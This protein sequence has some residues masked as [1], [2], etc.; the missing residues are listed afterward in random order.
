MSGGEILGRL[1]AE[2]ANPKA[3]IWYGGSADS[4]VTAQSE[5]LLTP[6]ISP[7]AADISSQQKDPEGYWTGIYIGYLGFICEKQWFEEHNMRYPTSWDDLLDPRF[8]K[9]IIVA[10]PGSSSTAYNLLSTMVQMKGEKDGIAYMAALDKQVK[11][12]TSSGSAPAKSVALGECAVG[13]TY[14]H[15]GIRLMKEGYTNIALS[16]PKEGTSYEL[17]SVAIVKGAPHE[18]AAKKFIDWCLTSECQEIGQKY[19][20]SYQFLTNPASHTPDEAKSL[21]NTKLIHYDFEWSGTNKNRLLEEWNT[22]TKH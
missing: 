21:E 6:Y 13:I 5:G 20:N 8:E 2:K 17:G 15:N 16:V 19:T 4:F 14:L 11:Q 1:R 7:N 9:Q 10:N 12:Y 18:E 22:A 3:D